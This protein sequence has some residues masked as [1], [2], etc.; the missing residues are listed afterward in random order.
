MTWYN[1]EKPSK[2]TVEYV[3]WHFAAVCRTGKRKVKAADVMVLQE[4][5]MIREEARTKTGTSQ[6]KAA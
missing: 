3:V 1:K 4:L 6:L 5:G 2:H